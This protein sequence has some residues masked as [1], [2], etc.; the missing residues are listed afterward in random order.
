MFV[1][2]LLELPAQTFFLFGPRGTG[3]STWL[4][5]K[6]P[7]ALRF[8]LL[9]SSIALQLTR[10]PHR[11]EALLGTATGRDWIIIDEIQKIPAL[12]DEVHRLIESRELRFAL[13]G[14]SARKL[15][16]GGANLLA[17]RAIRRQ[18]E[19]YTFAELG[20]RWDWTTALEWGGLPSLWNTPTQAAELLDA[21]LNNYLREEIREEGIVRQYAPFLRFLAIAGQ[22]N[23]QVINASNIAREALVPRSS[24][25]GYFTILTDTLVGHFLPAYQP[26]LKVRERAHPKFYWFD[27]G[28]A[29]A[30]AGRLF[31]PME[32]SAKGFALE[33]WIFHELRVF[34]ES[35]RK[36]R[37][38][39]YYHTTGQNEIDFIIEVRPARDNA[40]PRVI[41]VEAK[42]SS[43][44]NP[45]WERP[46][47]ELAAS[48]KIL[49]ER[50]IGVYCGRETLT[51]N[52]FHV[53]PI[54][55]FLRRLH[56]GDIF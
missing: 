36:H 1:E 14:S 7:Q 44:W 24:V 5:R 34:N 43:R 19:G 13:S 55:E 27:P 2:R 45:L 41:C 16:R 28:V 11:L 49:V 12:L 40:P 4:K 3:K 39:S 31:D 46:A 48:K 50:M 9:D 47:R 52:G 18:L 8:D 26:R 29:R 32:S 33:T 23:G 20:R 21:Y 53:W 25:D 54:N 38:I 30:A 51:S 56:A 37:P 6:L 22:L 17:N 42:L 15:K 35:R 10:E